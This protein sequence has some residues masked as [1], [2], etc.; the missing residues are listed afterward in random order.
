MSFRPAPLSFWAN[1]ITVGGFVPVIVL[2][3]IGFAYSFPLALVFFALATAWALLVFF[4]WAIATREYR[5]EGTTL[6]IEPHL[7]AGKR[8]DLLGVDEVAMKRQ[9]LRR[10]FAF[11]AMG[12][13]GP[14]GFH[15]RYRVSITRLAQAPGG[16]GQRHLEEFRV[17]CTTLQ[18]AIY[19]RTK[20]GVVVISPRD[21]A[22]VL[23]ACSAK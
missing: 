16:R 14:F 11:R 6:V 9:P 19:L 22:E 12:T 21:L 3:W 4:C 15:G 23:Q 5:I 10:A 18:K 8:Y 2:L 7:G 17:A 13:Y 20:S 1:V